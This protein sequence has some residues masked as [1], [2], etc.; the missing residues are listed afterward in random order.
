LPLRRWRG[1]KL[2][3]KIEAIESARKK[4]KMSGTKKGGVRR[5]KRKMHVDWRSFTSK[6]VTM[7]G[8]QRED[9]PARDGVVV[10]KTEGGGK[11]KRGSQLPVLR[12]GGDEKM[13][14]QKHSSHA[15]N[16]QQPRGKTKDHQSL[17]LKGGKGRMVL[18]R[19]IHGTSPEPKLGIMEVAGKLQ[20]N[21]RRVVKAQHLS[22][23]RND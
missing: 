10:K 22:T 17:A 1:G 18:G 4:E 2:G 7:G 21:A 9:S 19:P 23:T 14:P 15:R 12:R 8:V 13:S 6:G 16:E 5:K 3:A 20:E 11:K